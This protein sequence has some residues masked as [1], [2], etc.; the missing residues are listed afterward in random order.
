MGRGWR[1]QL[2]NGGPVAVL[3]L[4]G[5]H[6]GAPVGC[7][8]EGGLTMIQ[9]LVARTADALVRMGRPILAQLEA[10]PRLAVAA[11]SM[12][13]THSALEAK[14]D[15]LN[16]ARRAE[17]LARA[18]RDE[19]QRRLTVEIRAFAF[20]VLSLNG[21]HH[22]ADPYL[23]Y[24]PDGYGE[25]MQRTAASLEEFALMI[26][27]KLEGETD[28]EILGRRGRLEES[29]SRFAAAENAYRA[30]V[31]T[32][33]EAFELVQAEKREWTRGVVLARALAESACHYERA[34]VRLIFSPIRAPRRGGKVA[35][36]E[37]GNVEVS[38]VQPDVP[39][40]QFVPGLL[41]VDE[42]EAAA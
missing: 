20:D 13:V 7:A 22:D 42:E 35:T 26:L 31:R 11:G 15:A 18:E 32:R 23:L 4:P 9:R 19:E 27:T 28:P 3:I 16:V 14:V 8:L 6:A 33:K 1:V 5:C 25:V 37:T 2:R 12:R 21:N 24:F 41:S 30:A 29:Q 39:S 38:L 17:Q 36:V 34:Y 40:V 10:D